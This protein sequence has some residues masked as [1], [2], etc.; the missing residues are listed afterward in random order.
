[1]L[2][3]G[4]IMFLGQPTRVATTLRLALVRL[5]TPLVKL[6]EWIP[7]IRS[8]RELSRENASLRAENQQ[9][10]QQVRVLS[11]DV[12]QSLRLQ[13]VPFRVSPPLRALGANVIGRDA[14][15]WWKTIQLDRGA[16]HGVRENMAVVRGDSIVGK[17]ISVT[18]GESRVLLVSDPNCKV[19]AILQ[20]NRQP[21]VVAG[22]ED[23]FTREP[24]CRL[25][26]IQRD[27]TVHSNDLVVAS[28]LGGV[29]PK[30]FIIGHITSAGLNKNTGMYQ[31]ADVKP[32]ADL[33]RLEE[34]AIIMG[35]E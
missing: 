29:F 33:L 32:A 20:D 1:L 2:V 18:A 6:A 4:W 10:R 14:S 24:R 35:A 26:F 12:R 15:N 13:Q 9:L 8:Q 7:V 11:E 34:V 23:A 16:N 5:C 22:V 19:S 30:G 25:T 21:G 27:T 31:D 17:T 3:V 28:G